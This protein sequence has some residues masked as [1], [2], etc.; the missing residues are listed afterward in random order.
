MTATTTRFPVRPGPGTVTWEFS[1][2]LIQSMVIFPKEMTPATAVVRGA[3]WQLVRLLPSLYDRK[4]INMG[5]STKDSKKRSRTAEEDVNSIA[6]VKKSKLDESGNAEVTKVETEAPKV[7][8]EKKEKKEKKSKTETAEEPKEEKKEK[9]DKKKDKKE[10][11]DKAAATEESKTEEKTEESTDKKGKKKDKKKNKD[12]TEE[13]KTEDGGEEAT[14]EEEQSQANGAKGAR[15]IIFV[16]N[17]PYSITADNIK[18]H[19]ASV[20]PISVRLL[21]HRDNPTKSKGTAFV[22]FGR[23]DHMKTALEKF[24]HSEMLDDK[25]VPRKINVELSA[26]GGGKT[27]HRQDKIK[28]KNRKLN[29]ERL[30]RQQNQEKAKQEKAAAK[31]NGGDGDAAAA[32]GAAAPAPER[33]DEDAIHPSRRARVAYDGNPGGGDFDEE[34]SYG[35]GGGGGGFGGR[36][37]GRGGGRGRG[38]GRGG[39][40]RGRGG[41][42]G[43]GRGSYK[44]W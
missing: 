34:D 14:N 17:M 7:K 30:N 40:G 31:A 2:S 35:G 20:H 19:F 29:E 42:R 1:N 22:E 23:F 6:V 33:N 25:G 27:A 18:E 41:G 26:G 37:R 36:G 43:G 12:K 16:G 5:K 28:E 4:P 9:K 8:K 21:T 38:S 15:F 24:H 3:F 32:D 11:K 39:G 10:K 13:K 44:K